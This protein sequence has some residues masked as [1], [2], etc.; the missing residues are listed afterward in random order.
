MNDFFGQ[1][2]QLD[3]IV[4][5]CRPQ[6]RDL[7]EGRIIKFTPQKVKVEY[8][9]H[10]KYFQTYLADSTVFIKAPAERQTPDTDYWHPV[11][12]FIL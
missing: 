8:R 7:V 3:D 12:K 6:Y 10:G 9:T 5:F 4:A 1:P 11:D 2:L